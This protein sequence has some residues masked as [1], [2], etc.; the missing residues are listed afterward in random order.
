MRRIT[1]SE[2]RELKFG[3]MIKII[4][5]NSKLHRKNEE[6]YGITFGHKIGYDDGSTDETRIIAECMYNDWCMVYVMN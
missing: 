1:D 3:T 4:W 5:H 6:R 2:L